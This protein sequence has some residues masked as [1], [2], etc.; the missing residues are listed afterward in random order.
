MGV[1]SAARPDANLRK[2]EAITPWLLSFVL[3]CLAGVL[4]LSHVESLQSLG[5]VAGV[6][7][8][9][10]WR[11]S[12]AGF[13]LVRALTYIHLRLPHMRR[14]AARADVGQ[15]RHIYAVVCSFGMP[16]H[17]SRAVY[18]AL[19]ENCL[20]LGLPATIVAA[21]TSDAD[22]ALL[23]DLLR[24]YGQPPGITIV[25]QFQ[26][27]SGK[28][29][30]I[31][32]ALRAIARRHPDR[33]SLTIMLDG[34][35]VLTAGALL[36]SA[37]FM[38]ADPELGALT[39][40]ND[41]LFAPG[42]TARHWY[43]LRFAQRHLL[44]SSLSLSGRLLVLTGRFSLYRT[45]YLID[46]ACIAAVETD[47]VRH[48]LHGRIRFL[49]GDD[50]SLWHFMLGTGQ[51]MAYLPH[52]RALSF[53]ALPA[54]GGFVFGSS[55]LMIRWLG[56]MVRANGRALQ[57]GPR[58]IGLLLWWCLL[59]QRLSVGTVLL[60]LTT[61]LALGFLVDP[62][63]LLLYAG[64]VLLSRTVAA[65]VYG[66]VWGRFHPSWPAFLAYGQL[67]GGVLKLYLFFRPDRQSWTRQNIQAS[68]GG[69][70]GW[71]RRVAN[72]LFAV[73]LA[74]LIGLAA[75]LASGSAGVWS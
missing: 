56:N 2:V 3:C 15:L 43:Q 41:G 66:S 44:M 4:V 61:A 46:P 30:A 74:G 60:G 21:I 51:R 62:A 12:W 20:A 42:D 1:Q 45:R 7:A 70:N 27:G 18:S 29:A 57:L 22:C 19:I 52:V 69:R 54:G 28:R 53:E 11:Y 31:G 38:A 5:L 14:R 40:N 17:Q 34:D 33:R 58:R 13:H 64:W 23:A 65:L 48:W 55:R 16:A 24:V 35:V 8:I 73:T 59:D 68:G 72:G 47:E 32:M 26:D 36:E 71:R 39:T 67:W 6:G 50:K 25:A 75:S 9:A 37:R 10:V 63:Y 49:S